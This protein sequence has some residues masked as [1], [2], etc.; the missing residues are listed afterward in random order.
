LDDEEMDED[1]G[2]EKGN[3]GRE[4]L[5]SDNEYF[6]ENSRDN[7]NN[8]QTNEKNGRVVGESIPNQ[9]NKSKNNTN[10]HSE[11]EKITSKFST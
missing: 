5:I 11:N 9:L 2:P 8:S 3:Y 1:R 6:N 10:S 4:E 7:L